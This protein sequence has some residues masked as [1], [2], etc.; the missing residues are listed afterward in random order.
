M[1]PRFMRAAGYCETGETQP[2]SKQE[3]KNPQN[4]HR[5]S[6]MISHF[7][8]VLS[9]TPSSRT[10]LHPRSCTLTLP[11]AQLLVSAPPCLHSTPR[12]ELEVQPRECRLVFPH[13]MHQ[14][15][16]EYFRK[17]SW[18]TRNRMKWQLRLASFFFSPAFYSGDTR[19]PYAAALI[20]PANFGLSVPWRI[21]ASS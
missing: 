7:C 12:P 6:K 17:V 16:E 14:R 1:A 13:L 10:R 5:T 19:L 21:L 11:P 9:R 8:P 2:K 18:K 3:K 15:K 4:E 20:F